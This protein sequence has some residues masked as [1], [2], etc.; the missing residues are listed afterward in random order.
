MTGASPASVSSPG[1]EAWRSIRSELPG[2]SNPPQVLL[3]RAL[4]SSR[5]RHHQARDQFL[6]K[7]CH[8]HESSRLSDP[9]GSNAVTSALAKCG[10]EYVAEIGS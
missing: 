8:D 5:Q 1:T 9:L 3:D 2:G 10:H 6:D 7:E 4:G